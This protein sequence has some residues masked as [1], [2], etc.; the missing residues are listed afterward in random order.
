MD[1]DEGGLALAAKTQ[2][3]WNILHKTHSSCEQAFESL[4]NNEFR[5]QYGRL[6]ASLRDTADGMDLELMESRFRAYTEGKTHHQVT[7]PPM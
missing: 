5:H 6:R 3:L 4:Q 2:W 7:Q 1:P